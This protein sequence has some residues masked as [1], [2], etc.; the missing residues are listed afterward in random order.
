MRS[1]LKVKAISSDGKESA[2]ITAEAGIMSNP[3][4]MLHVSYGVT[5]TGDSFK[6]QSKYG[7]NMDFFDEGVDAELI[8][9]EGYP[10]LWRKTVQPAVL[11]HQ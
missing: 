6:Y 2:E 9:R 10:V 3:L 5:D 1:Q 11:S 7:A 4:P 8:R